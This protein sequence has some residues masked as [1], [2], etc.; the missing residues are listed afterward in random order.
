MLINIFQTETLYTVLTGFR[1]FEHFG[2]D[3]FIKNL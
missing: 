3:K 1:I 2:L